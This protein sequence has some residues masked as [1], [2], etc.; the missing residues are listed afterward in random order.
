MRVRPHQV[1]DDA[2][3]DR[4]RHFVWRAVRTLPIGNL[5]GGRGVALGEQRVVLRRIQ[6]ARLQLGDQEIVV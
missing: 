5:L 2:I 4:L 3:A 1:H 6:V